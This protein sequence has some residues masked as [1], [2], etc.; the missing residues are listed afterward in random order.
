MGNAVGTSTSYMAYFWASINPGALM[1]TLTS[2]S[3]GDALVQVSGVELPVWISYLIT[4]SLIIV[5]CLTIAIKKLRANM[6]S[7]R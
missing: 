7:N 3:M 5:I 1:L 6:K 4:Y 2:S